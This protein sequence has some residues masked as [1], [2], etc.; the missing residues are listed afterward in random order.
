MAICGKKIK[1]IKILLLPTIQSFEQIRGIISGRM[2]IKVKTKCQ[3]D[4]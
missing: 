4:P 1:N 3:A 2:L